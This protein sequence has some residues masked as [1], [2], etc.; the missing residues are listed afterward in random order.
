[1]SPFRPMTLQDL[2]RSPGMSVAA[3]ARL[4]GCNKSYLHHVMNGEKA[5]SRRV[6]IRIFRETGHKFGPI[7]TAT[8]ADID[9][10]ERFE[11][12]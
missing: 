9:V 1:M 2:V 11:A 7:K 5:M 8:D 10:L 12:A 6:A 4:A 3:L